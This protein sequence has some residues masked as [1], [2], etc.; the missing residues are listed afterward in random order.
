V[1]CTALFCSDA[2]LAQPNADLAMNAPDQFAWQLFIQ[3]ISRTASASTLFE[4]FATNENTFQPT[5]RYPSGPT[6]PVMRRPMLLRE[7]TNLPVSPLRR[8]INMAIGEE[9]R[10]NR[11]SFDFI[12]QHN[13]YKKSGL[14]AAFGTD[15]SFPVGSIE[16]KMMWGP[17][18]QIPGV[19]PQD[20]PKLFH[21]VETPSNGTWAL[22]SMH[23]ISKV[24]PNWTWA[25]FEHE[26]NPGR[27]DV[28]GCKD[29]FGAQTPYVP[30]NADA[31]KI[32]PDCAK[33]DAL[34]KLLAKANIETVFANYCLKGSQADFTDNSGLAT[35]LGNSL[36]ESPILATSSCMTCHASA[37]FNYDGVNSSTGIINGGG[38]LGP[39]Q[40]NWYWNV[41]GRPPIFQGQPGLSRVATSSDFVWSIPACA[42]DDT[43]D[44]PKIT[45][46]ADNSQ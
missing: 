2:A 8:T 44:P 39:I 15:I 9:V 22:Q 12:V 5:P 32:Y 35:R 27:C 10:R 14:K 33:S 26:L 18:D 4:T 17:I 3:V 36:M 46:C 40:A 23:I 1:F 20:V 11:A 30:P 28:L 41:S 7:A 31:D 19:S 21:V 45:P 6:P 37:S 25:T 24:V 38:P 29:A 43:V 34:V 42:I 13:L 16:L